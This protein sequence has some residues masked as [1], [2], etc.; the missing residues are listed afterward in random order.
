M[1]QKICIHQVYKKE[2]RPNVFRCYVDPSLI[3][4]SEKQFVGG[5]MPTMFL[6]RQMYLYLNSILTLIFFFWDLYK[7]GF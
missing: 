3:S 2:R 7:T 6:Q 4:L 5:K 1:K